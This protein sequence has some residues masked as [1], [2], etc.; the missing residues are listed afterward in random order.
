MIHGVPVAVI[1][2]AGYLL[3][4]FLA[5]K[6]AYRVMLALAVPALAFS[7]YL[8]HIE[9]HILGAWCLYCAISLGTISLITLLLIATV[10]NT[11]R[12]AAALLQNKKATLSDR[13]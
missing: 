6:R 7:L 2:I 4:G 13:L 1:G 11:F 9:E 3:L 10:I 12:Q 5:F 8:A